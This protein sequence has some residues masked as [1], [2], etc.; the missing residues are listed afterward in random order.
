MSFQDSENEQPGMNPY[1]PPT[2]GVGNL[3]TIQSVD[4]N[5]QLGKYEGRFYGSAVQGGIDIDNE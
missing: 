3:Q 2:Y 4:Q 1:D 5:V